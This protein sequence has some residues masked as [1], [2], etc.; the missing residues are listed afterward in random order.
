MIVVLGFFFRQIFCGKIPKDVFEDEL[1]PLFE[2][3]GKIWDMRL[4]MDPMTGLTRGYGF[5]TFCEKEAA[6]EAVNSVSIFFSFYWRISP[7]FLYFKSQ[8]QSR[9]VQSRMYQIMRFKSSS[10]RSYLGHKSMPVIC[11]AIWSTAC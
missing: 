7:K 1:I 11:N 8:R 3:C 9:V 6:T 4:M 2:K 5:I 10:G